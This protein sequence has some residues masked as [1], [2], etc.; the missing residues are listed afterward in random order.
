MSKVKNQADF[1][2]IQR[3]GVDAVEKTDLAKSIWLE[4]IAKGD[5]ASFCDAL[6]SCR[7]H[8]GKESCQPD[9]ILHDKIEW[10]RLATESFLQKK[11]LT[12]WHQ[13]ETFLE[14][15]LKDARDHWRQYDA[16]ETEP[17]YESYLQCVKDIQSILEARSW[18]MSEAEAWEL[19]HILRRIEFDV[20]R[21]ASIQELQTFCRQR[22]LD[23]DF[24][25]DWV[26]HAAVNPKKVLTLLAEVE[27]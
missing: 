21:G 20:A 3:E 7:V 8:A 9:A 19:T 25:W 1:N 24:L 22:N 23:K 15:F 27:I 11:I 6:N 14:C 16:W 17:H 26:R 4:R 18:R 13:Y 2:D 5:A 12:D 10:Y